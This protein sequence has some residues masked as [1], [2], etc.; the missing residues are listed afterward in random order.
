MISYKIL[1]CLSAAVICSL[2]LVAGCA[3]TAIL[4]LKL[5]PQD[6]TTYKV[7]IEME[8]SV[9]FEGSLPDEIT[10][11]GARNHNRIEMTFSR[12]IQNIDDKG[13]AVANITIKKLKYVSIYRDN[14]VLD[15]DSSRE[16]DRHM[17]MAKLIGQSYTIEIAPTGKVTKVIDIK[18]ADKAVRSASAPPKVALRLIDTS[19]IMERHGTPTLP[20][21][22]KNQLRTGES[23]SNIKAFDFRMLGSK[24]YE[25]IYTLKEIRNVDGRRLA[26][27]EMNAIPTAEMAEQLHKEQATPDFSKL[28]DDSGWQYTGRL[29]LDLTTGKVEEYLEKLRSEWVAVDTSAGR[30]EGKDPAVVR[31]TASRFYHLEKTD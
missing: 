26:V 29:K 24:S 21:I 5:T 2:L 8:D 9:K 30:E 7:T 16:K 11:K 22:D 3:Q 12:Q 1:S 20:I 19:V 17:P 10:T 15:F 28:F 25:R 18:Q 31:M 23:W 4:A 27:V 13:N 6:S 14:L